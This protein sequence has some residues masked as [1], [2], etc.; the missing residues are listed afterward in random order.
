MINDKIHPKTAQATRAYIADGGRLTCGGDVLVGLQRWET[1][2][3]KP[4]D[5]DALLDNMRDEVDAALAQG[6]S[7]LDAVPDNFTA[8]QRFTA[9]GFQAK[10]LDFAN[11]QMAGTSKSDVTP[12]ILAPHVLHREP[13]TLPAGTR[14]SVLVG[15]HCHKGA[16]AVADVEF[17]GFGK[18]ADGGV[19]LSFTC[20]DGVTDILL[21]TADP[22]K[23]T[24][25][26][27]TSAASGPRRADKTNP[28]H[29]G[30]VI[31]GEVLPVRSEGRRLA[32]GRGGLVH[33]GEHEDG[34][35]DHCAC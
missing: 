22:R 6:A 8:N 18:A 24:A 35:E 31:P 4:A 20:D 16:A 30:T 11:A 10:G 23:A 29:F 34:D 19:T 27:G 15:S 7:F 12:L 9:L 21:E 25:A 33:D 26:G 28:H 2:V 13:M 3:E 1:L 17:N 32:Q 14:F 5:V